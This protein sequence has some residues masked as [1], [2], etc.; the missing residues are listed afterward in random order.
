MKVISFTKPVSK[1]GTVLSLL[2]AVFSNESSCIIPL[3]EKQQKKNI[4]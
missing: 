2:L 1:S 3:E 4:K